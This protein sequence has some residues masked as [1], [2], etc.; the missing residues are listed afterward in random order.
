MKK[1]TGTLADLTG[2]I[3]DS[4]KD[5]YPENEAGQLAY[6]IV[7]HLLNY[8]KIDIHLKAGEKVSEDIF[9]QTHDIVRQLIENKPIQYILGFTEFFGIMLRVNHH[10][11]IPRQET[12]ELVDWIIKDH[13]GSHPVILDIG[14]GSGSIAVALAK[15]LHGAVVHGID[16]SA[17]ALSLASENAK[18]NHVDIHYSLHDI[19]DKQPFVHTARYNVIVSNPPYVTMSEKKLM[20]KNVTDYEPSAA[21][22]VS[23]NDPLVFYRKIAEFGLEH[24]DDHGSLYMEINENFGAALVQLYREKGYK[25]VI[26]RKDINGKDRMVKATMGPKRVL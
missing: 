5:I 3:R 16:N 24:L 8:S 9:Q 20:K 6:L 2:F 14:T 22:Y 1:L 25:D 4:L 21:L 17:Q 11:L 13:S 10:V 19:L 26:L 12:E 7:N 23:D 18:I 15:N